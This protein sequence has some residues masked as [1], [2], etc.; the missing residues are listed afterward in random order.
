MSKRVLSLALGLVVVLCVFGSAFAALQRHRQRQA[1]ERLHTY[2][3]SMTGGPPSMGGAVVMQVLQTGANSQM[4]SDWGADVLMLAAFRGEADA[5]R[6][7]LRQGFDASATDS[8]D[9]TPLHYACMSGNPEVVRLLLAHGAEVDV[10][11]RAGGTPLAEAAFYESPKITG[12]LLAKGANPNHRDRL[13]ATP[14]MRAAS[15]SRRG[16]GAVQVAR[17]L[18][19]QGADPNVHDRTG[20]SALNLAANHRFASMV[21]VLKEAGARR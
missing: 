9:Q 4:R 19:K 6:H 5:V 13:G 3:I 18:L 20:E 8:H 12:L 16:P 2:F 14:L 17:Q 21:Q 11:D 7:L 10:E 1:D 15:G